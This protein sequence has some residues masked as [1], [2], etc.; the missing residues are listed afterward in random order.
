MY[1][2]IQLFENKEKCVM[3]YVKLCQW[4]SK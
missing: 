2:T 3:L 1:K 4:L